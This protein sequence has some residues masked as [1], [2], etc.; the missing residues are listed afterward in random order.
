MFGTPII[1]SDS[2]AIPELLNS[3]IGFVCAEEANC[4]NAISNIDRIE[5]E[6]CRAPAVERFHY[7]RMARGYVEQYAAEIRSFRTIQN[8]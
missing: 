4:V 5:S 7:L 1:G 8:C 6:A 3:T 2:G